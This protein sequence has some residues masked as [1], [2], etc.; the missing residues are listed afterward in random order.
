[1]CTLLIEA[2]ARTDIH[3]EAAL[4][5]SKDVQK[6]LKENAKQVNAQLRDSTRPLLWAVAGCRPAMCRL[7][8]SKDAHVNAPDTDRRSPG[9]LL[10]AARGYTEIAEILLDSEAEVNSGSA[11]GDWTP[12]HK[13][14]YRGHARM[15]RLLLKRGA[16][17]NAAD[18]TGTTPLYLAAS[19][20]ASPEVCR[21]LLKHG[22]KVNAVDKHGWTPL[23]RAEQ[24]EKKEVVELLKKHGGISGRK[25][26]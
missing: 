17:V 18:N 3:I 6:R 26:K 9:L 4:G 25:N 5:K 11:Q 2:G 10:A 16:D 13:A 15:C 1:M 7:L 24:L 8:I 14:A 23:D 21:I 20:H 22:A 19:D 12:L